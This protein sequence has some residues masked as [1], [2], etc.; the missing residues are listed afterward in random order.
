ME[1][2]RDA[3]AGRHHVVHDQRHDVPPGRHHEIGGTTYDDPIGG[4][5]LLIEP[6]DD[7]SFTFDTYDT[8]LIATTSGTSPDRASWEVTGDTLFG[9]VFFDGESSEWRCSTSAPHDEMSCEIW[10]GQDDA[11][12]RTIAIAYTERL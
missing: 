10:G 3:A 2:L 11:D 6:L 9:L 1:R 5:V 7:G 8:Q 12:G 4:G